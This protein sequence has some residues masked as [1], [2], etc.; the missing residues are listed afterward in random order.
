MHRRGAVLVCVALLVACSSGT[1]PG[2]ATSSVG[3]A[4]SSS[5][6]VAAAAAPVADPSLSAFRLLD[7]SGYSAAL[8]E[9]VVAVEDD[10][11]F[12]DPSGGHRSTTRVATAAGE[13][14]DV[15]LHS[16]ADEAA[17]TTE[18]RQLAS[19]GDAGSPTSAL[20][21]LGDESVAAGGKVFVRKG[22]Q[23]L[24]VEADLGGKTGIDLGTI[25]ANG[26]DPTAVIAG[27]QV[28]AA[29]LAAP[30][31]SKLTGQTGPADAVALPDTAIDPCDP[32]A[33]AT[34]EQVYG[35]ADVR[36]TYEK[37]ANPPALGCVLEANGLSTPIEITTVT[38]TQ[39][40]SALS[41]TTA[42]AQFQSD[43]AGTPGAA[44]SADAIVSPLLEYSEVL[45]TDPFGWI[46]QI[47]FPRRSD[48][49]CGGLDQLA[50]IKR[51]EEFVNN[52][53]RAMSPKPR[54]SAAALQ[55]IADDYQKLAD[56]FRQQAE[57]ARS[58]NSS[59]K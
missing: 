19:G 32:V 48:E 12:P 37:T 10:G 44:T 52:L 51:G 17:A 23:V 57:S 1:K 49:P 25:K 26:G 18:F 8:G 35:V 16:A 20:P 2:A 43:G 30:L 59:C 34:V 31:A 54:P 24:A 7:V 38:D 41:A 15:T 3:G 36:A 46:I 9:P 28:K 47:G 21:G 39:L 13:V 50:Q 42:A 11:G 5:S 29:A 53:L 6:G 56:V 40:A 14:F 58:T 45:E 4:G 33:I 27:L 55:R 22:A